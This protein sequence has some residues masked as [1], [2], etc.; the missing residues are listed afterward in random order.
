MKHMSTA[1]ALALAL[2]FLIVSCSKDK[3]T[4]VAPSGVEGAHHSRRV[5]ETCTPTTLTVSNTTQ[6]A[7]AWATLCDGDVIHIPANTTITWTGAPPST[8][9]GANNWFCATNVSFTIEG[10]DT[11]SV[12]EVNSLG[13]THHFLDA[14]DDGTDGTHAI[15]IQNV[16]FIR[17]N[18]GSGFIKIA[19]YNS[20]V[21]TNVVMDLLDQDFAVNCKNLLIDGLDLESNGVGLDL[22]AN[23]NLGQFSHTVENSKLR[24]RSS[25]AGPVIIDLGNTQDGTITFQDNVLSAHGGD[26]DHWLE[27]TG[28]I[29]SSHTV[30]VDLIDNDFKKRT[31]LIYG[32]ATTSGSHLILD[33]DCNNSS[34]HACPDSLVVLDSSN[35]F[36]LS[37]EQTPTWK[38]DY[39]A[40]ISNFSLGSVTNQEACI[41]GDSAWVKFEVGHTSGAEPAMHVYARWADDNCTTSPQNVKAVWNAG[42]SKWNAH[43]YIGDVMDGSFYWK[44]T[45]QLCTSNVAGTC[46]I[47]TTRPCDGVEDPTDFTSQ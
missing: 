4:E 18:N 44:G 13:S 39:G 36:D 16:K 33:L 41:F 42:T 14:G 20:V 30:N 28:Y 37:Y 7:A 6:F 3:P 34:L 19:G 9:R 2:G 23:S 43:F 15:T 38:L 21:V 22:G 45:G 11:T 47:R 25:A 46:Q 32:I 40:C 35:H 26:G 27:T 29:Q 10:E 17:D 5:L 12:I 31:V 8:C 1:H 24:A